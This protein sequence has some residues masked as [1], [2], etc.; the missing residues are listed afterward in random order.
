MEKD[1]E[2]SLDEFAG[3]ALREQFNLA[4]REVM[5]NIA[6]PNTSHKVKRGLGIAFQFITDDNRELVQVEFTVTPKLAAAKGVS[7]N[8]I[9]SRGLDGRIKSGEFS[10]DRNQVHMQVSSNGDIALEPAN[11]QS[12]PPKLKLAVVNQ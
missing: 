2:Y 11:E 10:R 6:N 3:G 4:M 9:I 7:T 8:I 5:D 1:F 12:A